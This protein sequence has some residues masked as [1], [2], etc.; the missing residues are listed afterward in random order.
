MLYIQHGRGES[1]CGEEENWGWWESG[2]L[3]A[4]LMTLKGHRICITWAGGWPKNICFLSSQLTMGKKKHRNTRTREVL[5][6]GGCSEHQHQPT[7]IPTP[8]LPRF[9]G[10]QSNYK[11]VSRV[12]AGLELSHLLR[13][14]KDLWLQALVWDAETGTISLTRLTQESMALPVFRSPIWNR[15]LNPFCQDPLEELLWMAHFVT[16]RSRS[17]GFHVS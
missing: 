6:V 15:T 11:R 13:E 4:C 10:E 2:K 3:A 9:K 17:K 8:L 7:S 5:V 1:V 12:P 14:S 16:T